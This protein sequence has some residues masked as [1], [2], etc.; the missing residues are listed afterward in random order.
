MTIK[1]RLDIR[2]NAEKYAYQYFT[3]LCDASC[4]ETFFRN[5]GYTVKMQFLSNDEWV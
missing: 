2:T 4:A 3:S 5:Q 1:Y